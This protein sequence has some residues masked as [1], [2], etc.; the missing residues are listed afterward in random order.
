MD[1]HTVE[2]YF[3]K[4]ET[5]VTGLITLDDDQTAA[6]A[7]DKSKIE[8]KSH[9]DPAPRDGL[10]NTIPQLDHGKMLPRYHE[11]DTLL[12]NVED[13]KLTDEEKELAKTEFDKKIGVAPAAVDLLSRCL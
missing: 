5:N 7:A 2:R 3:T 6:A 10:L 13:G 11:H 1:D 4:S 12:E 8:Y 9:T